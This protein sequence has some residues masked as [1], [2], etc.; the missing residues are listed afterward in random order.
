MDKRR[1]PGC[2]LLLD[3]ELGAEPFRKLDKNYEAVL[4]NEQ[5]IRNSLAMLMKVYI[6]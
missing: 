1:N 6:E 5:P 4:T 3:R 2:G